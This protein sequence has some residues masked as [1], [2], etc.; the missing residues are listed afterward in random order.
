MTTGAKGEELTHPQKILK[1]KKWKIKNSHEVQLQR[2]PNKTQPI[3][4]KKLYKIKTELK[5]EKC[6][7]IIINV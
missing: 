5:K 1:N 4:K 7:V 2:D 6:V 3:T